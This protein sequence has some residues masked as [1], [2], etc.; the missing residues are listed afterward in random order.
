MC[1]VGKLLNKYTSG[2]IPKALKFIPS[3]P[4]WEERLYLTEPDKWSPHALY[5]ATIIFASGMGVNKV[6]RF[7]KFVLLPRVREEIRKNKT[8]H[9]ALYQ[10]LK[11]ACYKQAAF[12]KGILLPLCE[13]CFCYMVDLR[14]VCFI[15]FEQVYVHAYI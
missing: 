4:S 5:Q 10:S 3:Q 2:K 11:K 9:P 7:Y 12:I 8:L 6:A 14:L 1:R 15:A 13:V